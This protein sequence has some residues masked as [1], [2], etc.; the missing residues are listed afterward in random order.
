VL[1]LAHG[2]RLS[3]QAQLPP[4]TVRD[5]VRG[6][7]RAV[8]AAL[9]ARVGACTIEVQAVL[10]PAQLSSRSTVARGSLKIELASSGVEPHD[11]ALEL[12]ISIAR[13][14]WERAIPAEREAWLRL[15]AAEID[16]AVSGEIDDEV[17]ELKRVLLTSRVAVCNAAVI[18]DYA[19]ASFAATL[20]EYV[21][22]LWHDVTVRDGPAY[23]LPLVLRRRLELFARWFPPSRGRRVFA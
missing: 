10:D 6:P 2:W 7:V 19:A 5:F 4:E 20:A 14:A 17:L 3:N 12:L 18:E 11:L 23:L 13:R 9:A 15:L 16:T 22:C 21:H 8:P 1:R